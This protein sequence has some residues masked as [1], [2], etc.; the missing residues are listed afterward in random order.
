MTTIPRSALRFDC[1]VCGMNVR[2]DE[3]HPHMFC[4]LFR[5]GVDPRKISRLDVQQWLDTFGEDHR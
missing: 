3:F 2:G 1:A 4:V 5:A